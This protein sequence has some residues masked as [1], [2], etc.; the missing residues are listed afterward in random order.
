MDKPLTTYHEFK[1]VD[2][3]TVKM[4]LSF[5]SVYQLKK[6][7]KELYKRYNKIFVEQ[8][9]KNYEYDELDNLSILYAAYVCANLNDENL[10]DEE[11]FLIMCGSNRERIGEAME[12]LIKPKN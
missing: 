2:G 4:S 8:N 9:K 10:M 12:A 1:L 3:S 7:N 6:V 5:Y 11:T